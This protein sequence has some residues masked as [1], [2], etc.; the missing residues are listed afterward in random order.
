[1]VVCA[2]VWLVFILVPLSS[3]GP[4]E[5]KLTVAY[6]T[7]TNETWQRVAFFAVTNWGNSAA[8]GFD[9]G[10]IE[11]FGQ[12]QKLK[13][14][15]Q[16]KIHRLLPG[17]GEVVKVFLPSGLIGRWRFTTGYAHDGLES[18]FAGWGR[19]LGSRVHWLVNKL[20]PSFVVSLDVIATSD[21]IDK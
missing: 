18:R 16:T 15:C 21:W 2:A 10:E 3:G 7:Q 5:P 13:V 9:I 19:G 20:T 17:N 8:I 12:T 11:M 6:L 1:L 14:G 4:R